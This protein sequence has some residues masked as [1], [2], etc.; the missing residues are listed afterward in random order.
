MSSLQPVVPCCSL[1]PFRS[2]PNLDLGLPTPPSP[3]RT[4]PLQPTGSISWTPRPSF[5]SL[6]ASRT[7]VQH[8][9]APGGAHLLKCLTCSLA[10]NDAH[11][12]IFHVS[13]PPTAALLLQASRTTEQW[14]LCH[15][16]SFGQTS[17]SPKIRYK[18]IGGR[19][20][21]IKEKGLQRQAG[22]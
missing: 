8:L 7:Y 9:V 14:L 2:T 12:S 16:T 15:T 11:D 4:F 22:C 6:H 20:T 5:H 17:W 21:L 13:C 10:A 3:H 18:A 19:V 1:P